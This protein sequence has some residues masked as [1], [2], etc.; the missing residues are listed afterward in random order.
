MCSRRGNMG[1][2][3]EPTWRKLKLCKRDTERKLSA[4]PAVRPRHG[5]VRGAPHGGKTE[6]LQSD[7]WIRFSA[8]PGEL[9]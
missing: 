1:S 4:N 8:T 2:A 9:Q 7:T 6:R 5:R 3:S